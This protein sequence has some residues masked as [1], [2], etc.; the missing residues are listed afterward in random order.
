MLI[1]PAKQ[2][3]VPQAGSSM[4]AISIILFLIWWA[5]E[6]PMVWGENPN[7]I[8]S[9]NTAFGKSELDKMKHDDVI[10]YLCG[11]YERWVEFE[12]Q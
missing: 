4:L 7:R 6:H 5:N 9:S 3:G 10:T 1:N 12:T 11:V 2:P 8:F